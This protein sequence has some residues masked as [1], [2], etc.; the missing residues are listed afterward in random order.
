MI[1]KVL[2]KTTSDICKRMAYEVSA[3]ACNWATY[4]PKEPKCLKNI[5]ND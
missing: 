1:H 2:L 4:Q 3:S 5:K